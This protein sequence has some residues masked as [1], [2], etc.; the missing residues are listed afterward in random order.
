VKNAVF[1][2]AASVAC[3]AAGADDYYEQMNRLKGLDQRCEQTRAT[4]LAP[5]RERYLQKCMKDRHKTLQDCKQEAA[6]Y[7]DSTTGPNRNLVKGLYYDL[8]EC[9][10]AAEAWEAWKKSRPGVR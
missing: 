10:Q 3:A 4:K 8:P 6:T 9:Q 7:G 5:I 1:L 2:L